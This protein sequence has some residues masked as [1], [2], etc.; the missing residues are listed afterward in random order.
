MSSRRKTFGRGA[1]IASAVGTGAAF[2][3]ANRGTEYVRDQL[4]AHVSVSTISDTILPAIAATPFHL[5]LA[6]PDVMAGAIG[7]VVVPLGVLYAYT[8]QK[9][10]RPGEEHGSAAWASPRD[11]KKLSERDRSRRLQFTATE[12]LSTDTRRTR[13]NNN[14]CVIG[15]SGTGKTRS[16]VGPNIRQVE[17]SK[18]ITDP[19]GELYRDYADALRAD[20]YAVRQFNLIDMAKSECFN[21]MK[22]FDEQ[23]PETSIAQ[24]TETIMA[25]TSGS[26]DGA[27]EGFWERAERALLQALIAY[28]WATTTEDDEREPSLVEVV[29]LQKGMEASEGDKADSFKSAVDRRFEVAREIVA[30]W[31]EDPS[32][33]DDQTIMKVLDIACRQYR[34]FEQ[35]AGET[36]KSIII[37]LGVRLA[38]LDMADVSRIVGSDTLE[39]DQI[40]YERTAVFLSIPDTHQTFKFIAA[41]FWQ[42]LFEKNVY[43]ADHEPNGQLPIPL[44]AFL[45][46]FANIGKIPGFPILMSTIRSRSISASV[47]VQTHSQGKAL[48]KDDW[49]TIV[50]N[51][52]S[53]LFLGGADLETNKWL[54]QLL[55]DETISSEDISRS[56]GSSGSWSRSE[57]SLK[58]SLMTPDEIAQMSNDDALLLIRGLK[59][60][61]SRKAKV[62]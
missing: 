56:Y 25:N 16:Y 36:K 35:G 21:P 47:I 4:A 29:N 60:F 22:Y 32:I 33:A 11:I 15:A 48:W 10:K 7:A 20:G 37:S 49:A 51:C 59:P 2:F 27:G 18:A 3:A 8:G 46:E 58:R 14:V 13:R 28:V 17:M 24:L 52:D 62:A 42:S 55:G 45:D 30:E 38:P 39:L 12:A 1:A 43:I 53:L 6:Q 23:A 26:K 31:R 40:G 61:R 19:K 50:G 9:N 54:S 44:H 41:M 5:S 34:T 57:R